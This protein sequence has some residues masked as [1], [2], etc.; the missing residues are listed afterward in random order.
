MVQFLSQF[1]FTLVAWYLWGKSVAIHNMGAPGHGIVVSGRWLMTPQKNMVPQSYYIMASSGTRT[2]CDMP[3]DFSLNVHTPS[4]QK[5]I[6]NHPLTSLWRSKTESNGGLY[7]LFSKDNFFV[8]KP[9]LSHMLRS[10]PIRLARTS[11][12]FLAYVR[13]RV[14]VPRAPGVWGSQISR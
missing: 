8:F 1:Q 3:K 7:F 13:R 6:L 11:N 10:S 4:P 9:S 12:S 5:N 14:K 2:Q